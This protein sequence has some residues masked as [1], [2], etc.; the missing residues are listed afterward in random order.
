MFI[1]FIVKYESSEEIN[2]EDMMKAESADEDIYIRIYRNETYKK[3]VKTL[4]P[5]L[6]ARGYLDVLLPSENG[7]N[8]Q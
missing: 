2:L 4:L 8:L 7:E 6:D 3:A 1:L 5:F